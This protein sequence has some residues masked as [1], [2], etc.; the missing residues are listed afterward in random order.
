MA[1]LFTRGET[2]ALVVTTLGTGDDEQFVDPWKAPIRKTSFALNPRHF[3]WAKGRVAP[4]RREIGRKA[5][6]AP[7]KAMGAG[8]TSLPPAVS[9]FPVQRLSSMAPRVRAC[10]R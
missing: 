10:W 2:Q 7:L 8:K 3:P 5:G 9:K 1:P 4:G 6:M